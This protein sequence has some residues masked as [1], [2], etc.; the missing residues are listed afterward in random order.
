[1]TELITLHHPPE[2]ASKEHTNKLLFQSIAI[3]GELQPTNALE[4]LLSVQMIAVH[5]TAMRFIT[6][7]TAPSQTVEGAD[8]HVLRATRLM[9]LFTEQTEALARLKGKSGQ[10]RVVVERVTVNHGGQAVVG[11][12]TT[13]NRGI[14]EGDDEK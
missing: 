13:T 5:R 12:V 2:A 11:A 1:M 8:L 6:R 4:A 10:Q 9:R 7:A 14:G 3:M